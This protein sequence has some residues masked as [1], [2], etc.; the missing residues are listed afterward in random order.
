M[1]EYILRYRQADDFL[2]FLTSY[3]FVS[4]LRHTLAR[5]LAYMSEARFRSQQTS[6]IAFVRSQTL[7]PKAI[8]FIILV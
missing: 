2:S 8:V 7:S 6:L 3:L 1:S 4:S 5:L